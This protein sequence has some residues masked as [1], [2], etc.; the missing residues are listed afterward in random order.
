M[1]TQDFADVR[2]AT[3]QYPDEMTEVTEEDM[4]KSERLSKDHA[5]GVRSAMANR[6]DFT[7]CMSL[8]AYMQTRDHT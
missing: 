4:Q 1:Q 7:C 5:L 6:Y 2:S 3:L 8:H